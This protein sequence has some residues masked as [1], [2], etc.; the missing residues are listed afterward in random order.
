MTTLV[1]AENEGPGCTLDTETF[2][3]DL[4][5]NEPSWRLTVDGTVMRFA[6]IGADPVEATATWPVPS[7]GTVRLAGSVDDDTIDVV[8]E[9]ARCRDSMS[10]AF[11]S[12]TAAV[13]IGSREFRGCAIA[14]RQWRS[15][16]TPSSSAT[17]GS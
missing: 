17:D 15:K 13:T 6:T 3:F 10:G 14:G 5:G 16:L 2:D 11:Y 4:R 1:R 9:T 8:V 12:M 7:P